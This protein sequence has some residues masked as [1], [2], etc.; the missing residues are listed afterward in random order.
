M[1]SVNVRPAS[2]PA[3]YVRLE[4]GPRKVSL[5]VFAAD[6]VSDAS[7]VIGGWIPCQGNRVGCHT[8]HTQV[9]RRC[10][11]GSILSGLDRGDSYDQSE[12]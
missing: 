10:R 5:L 9:G 1:N 12:Q 4:E 3:R 11:W 8:R 6:L 2:R 7:R